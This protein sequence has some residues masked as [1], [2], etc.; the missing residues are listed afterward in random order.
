MC[1]IEIR[2]FFVGIT[3]STVLHTPLDLHVG[4]ILGGLGATILPLGCPRRPLEPLL[5]P[6]WCHWALVGRP[7]GLSKG[8]WDPSRP[9]VLFG[10]SAVVVWTSPLFHSHSELEANKK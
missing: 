7:L 2:V 10:G 9:V 3:F 1:R 8:L 5:G 6:R 4:I